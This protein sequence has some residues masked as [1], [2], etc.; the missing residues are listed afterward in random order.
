M[1]TLREVAGGLIFLLAGIVKPTALPIKPTNAPTY[2]PESV[3]HYPSAF[4]SPYLLLSPRTRLGSSIYSRGPA[5]SPVVRSFYISSSQMGRKRT[6]EDRRRHTEGNGYVNDKTAAGVDDTP[7][8][9][10]VLDYTKEK[11]DI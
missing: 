7:V 10:N 11:Y 3:Q 4:L 8:L 1:A 9:H 2:T 6:A 5:S